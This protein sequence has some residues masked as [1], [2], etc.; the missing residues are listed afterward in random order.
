MI[1]IKLKKGIIFI[2]TKIIVTEFTMLTLHIY[3]VHVFISHI[4]DNNKLFKKKLLI[5][6]VL[7]SGCTY[8]K[9]EEKQESARSMTHR[10][11]QKQRPC[12]Q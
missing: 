9:E 2:V 1:F 11:S 3:F 8:V 7:F 4:N 6:N 12:L 5:H 10:A